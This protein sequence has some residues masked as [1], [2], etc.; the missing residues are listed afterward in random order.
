[1]ESE[2]ITDSSC[3]YTGKDN[4][5]RTGLWTSCTHS[6][7]GGLQ[8]V[9]L[10]SDSKS[11]WLLSDSRSDW[12]LFVLQIC[13]YTAAEMNFLGAA[14]A[15]LIPKS[16]VSSWLCLPWPLMLGVYSNILLHHIRFV[17]AL[18]VTVLGYWWQEWFSFAAKL[19]NVIDIRKNKYYKFPSDELA[20]LSW[21]STFTRTSVT[22]RI[23]HFTHRIKQM[24]VKLRP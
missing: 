17:L 1:M 20:L 19:F 8:S 21:L 23:P 10:M 13:S 12:L 7:F 2:C 16:R 15:A 6:L 11:D 5:Y 4:Q 24:H 18:F 3:C 14:T 22:C 9:E